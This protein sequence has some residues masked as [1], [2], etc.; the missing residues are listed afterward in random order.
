MT[1]CTPDKKPQRQLESLFWPIEEVPVHFNPLTQASE[2]YFIVEKN[3]LNSLVEFKVEKNILKCALCKSYNFDTSLKK[4][5]LEFK[6]NI[7]FH[8]SSPLSLKIIKESLEKYGTKESLYSRSYGEL[9]S[10][11]EVAWNEKGNKVVFHFRDNARK[12]LEFLNQV[13][14]FK[15]DKDNIKNPLV[16]TGPFRLSVLRSHLVLE[17]HLNHINPKII[18]KRKNKNQAESFIQYLT[19]P[20]DFYIYKSKKKNYLSI[21]LDKIPWVWK[22]DVLYNTKNISSLEANRIS[23]S[24]FKVVNS[25]FSKVCLYNAKMG[26]DSRSGF[27]HIKIKSSEEIKKI[28]NIKIIYFEKEL[29]ECLAWLIYESKK[30]GYEFEIQYVPVSKRFETIRSID[31]DLIVQTGLDYKSKNYLSSQFSSDGLYNFTNFSNKK[32]DMLFSQ[33]DNEFVFKDYN[34]LSELIH[35]EVDLQD[36]YVIRLLG[37][38]PEL[39]V[40]KNVKFTYDNGDHNPFEFWRWKKN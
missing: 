10:T 32:V 9:M 25:G 35:K 16:G 26:I 37:P 20:K 19:T 5:S 34:E 27:K 2:A 40:P 33:R 13:K 24:F 3:I 18:L 7:K 31:Y 4:L 17:P 15:Y 11:T 36:P 12:N 21:Q 29:K 14:I 22:F 28:K 39:L 23:D 8:D 6:K 30:W 1:G 38:V